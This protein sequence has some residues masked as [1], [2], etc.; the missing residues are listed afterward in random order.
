MSTP[1]MG[2]GSKIYMRAKQF[3]LSDLTGIRVEADS[4]KGPDDPC[5]LYWETSTAKLVVAP[6][7]HDRLCELGNEPEKL[8]AF[9]RSL[10][11]RE[12]GFPITLDMHAFAN[13]AMAMP[14]IGKMNPKKE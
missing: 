11:V 7:V 13:F 4:S 5:D 10:D 6:P 1:I 9:L 14:M 3:P 8:E 2:H 12:I